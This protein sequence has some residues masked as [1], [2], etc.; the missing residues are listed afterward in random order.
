MAQIQREGLK[1]NHIFALYY[2]DI[3]IYNINVL[4]IDV[5]FLG[6]LQREH[7]LAGW[8]FGHSL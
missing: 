3:Y 7:Q 4:S 5:S 2:F 6:L 1:L 8:I